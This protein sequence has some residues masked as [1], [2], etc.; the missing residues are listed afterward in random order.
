[1]CLC[2]GMW[3]TLYTLVS[4]LY[5]LYNCILSLVSTAV[6]STLA[7]GAA[8]TVRVVYIIDEI[9]CEKSILIG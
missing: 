9:R 5:T 7:S 8:L 2:V 4:R 1:M 6:L 3:K